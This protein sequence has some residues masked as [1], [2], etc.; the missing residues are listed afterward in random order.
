MPRG[1]G[2]AAATRMKSKA[3]THREITGDRMTIEELQMQVLGTKLRACMDTVLG[4]PQ[5]FHSS[6]SKRGSA[7]DLQFLVDLGKKLASKAVLFPPSNRHVPLCSG[8]HSAVG[9]YYEFV[10][11]ELYCGSPTASF[12]QIVKSLRCRFVP[13]L[14]SRMSGITNEGL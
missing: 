11:L 7:N 6:V 1:D 13:Y 10:T 8:S 5:T 12:G 9:D 14:F 2:A 4:D 3:G